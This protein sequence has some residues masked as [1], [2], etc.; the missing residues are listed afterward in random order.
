MTPDQPDPLAQAIADGRQ[1]DWESAKAAAPDDAARNLVRELAVIAAIAEVHCVTTSADDQRIVV[2]EPSTV[3]DIPTW[4]SF[5]LLEKIGQGA[6]GEVYR[7][8]DT[9]LDR[10]VALKLL[11]A[12]LLDA[13][14]STI[15]E[16]SLLARV[17]HPN[18]VTIHGAERIGDRVGIWMEFVKG[19]TLD[20]ILEERAH[21]T[22]P[23]VV[24]IGI[25]VCRAVAAVHGAGLLHRDI[26]AQNVMRAEDGRI[27][28]MDFGAGRMLAAGNGPDLAGTPLY[29]APEV[30]RGEPA[31]VQSDIYSAGV[32]LYRL[33]AG[34]FPV[35]ARTIGEV[36][37]CHERGER[38]PIQQA[39]PEVPAQLARLIERATHPDPGER[40]ASADAFA[41]TLASSGRRAKV[42]RVAWAA[43]LLAVVSAGVAGW[44][45]VGRR[46]GTAD[47]NPPNGGLARSPAAVAPED[48]WQARGSALLGRRGLPNAQQAAVLYERA[49]ASHANSAAAH[50]GLAQAH[51]LMSFPDRG[52]SFDAAYPIMRKEATLALQLDPQSSEAHAAIGWVYAFE[53]NW[54][55]A[56][57]AF[58]EAIRLN[59]AL[60][61]NYTSY[62]VAVLH[63]LRRFD[64]ALRLLEVAG[65]HDPQS[66]NV[67]REIGEVQFYA[68]RYADAIDTLQR[69]R[70][71]DPDFAFVQTYLAR[72]L[73]LA[74]RI[75]EALAL[76]QP[77]AIWPAQA[78]VRIGRRK[79][80]EALA[81]EHAAR[82]HGS[83]LIAAALGN[84]AGVMDALERAAAT[85]PHRMGR[86]L[87]EPELA[88]FRG[89]AWFV[90]LRQAFGLP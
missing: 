10:E 28:L 29:L 80:A 4:G 51:A 54:S 61:L 55:D 73:I 72:A 17:R 36:R 71:A 53:R 49:I 1:V 8:L 56:E 38:T 7:A 82:P 63:P 18:V 32:L 48:D 13:A 12:E 46:A 87:N 45:A 26:K 64:E 68:G 24:A 76:W 58:E 42:R 19:R 75:D 3:P 85:A 60:V 74:D 83:A 57:R 59:P 86:L 22:E 40:F 16:G 52:T 11:P 65:Q 66:L 5:R 23:E 77:V 39:R 79:E 70:T 20:E 44:G 34:S 6:Y 30:L 47:S 15:R 21:L 89:E 84:T 41:A 88:P 43:A 25:Q 81:A 9:R 33:A 31:T 69:V 2:A 27:V 67:Q 50:A 35:H 14:T 78:Y 62:S 90:A 37:Q